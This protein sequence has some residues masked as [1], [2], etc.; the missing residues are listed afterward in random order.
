MYQAFG[1]FRG[2][3]DSGFDLGLGHVGHQAHE[4]QYKFRVGM[5]DDSQVG[6]GAFRDILWQLDIEL[7]GVIFCIHIVHSAIFLLFLT[8]C[9]FLKYLPLLFLGYFFRLLMFSFPQLFS[10]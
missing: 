3:D 5:A 8:Y 10:S 1:V 7:I 2:Y 6:V 9:P 4:I